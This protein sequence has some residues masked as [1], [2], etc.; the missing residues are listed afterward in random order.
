MAKRALAA[1]RISVKKD[2]STSIERQDDII[3]AWIERERHQH[4][5]TAV[6]RNVSASKTNPFSRPALGPWLN[7]RVADF[8]VLVF[9]RMDRAV[10][11]MGD[12]HKLMD[13]AK[14]YQKQVVFCEGPGSEYEF[15]FTGSGDDSKLELAMLLATVIA[16]AARIESMNV[17]DRVKSSHEYLR[18]NGE[19]GG[20]MIPYGLKPQRKRGA[21]R[22]WELV[23][24][25]ETLPV[26]LDIVD[27]VTSG[28]RL[29]PICNDLN[30]A[31]IPTPR[32]YW[33]D[34]K[35]AERA[36]EYVEGEAP[37]SEPPAKRRLWSTQGL[38]SILTS[39][40]LLGEW[41]FEGSLNVR[42]DGEPIPRCAPILTQT[43]WND[44]QGAL[45]EISIPSK[46]KYSEPNPL[47]GVAMCARC[48]SPFYLKQEKQKGRLYSNL[49]C[50]SRHGGNKSCSQPTI[51]LAYAKEIVEQ[52]TMLAIGSF[53]ATRRQFI[54][55][56]DRSEELARL[57]Q[58]VR[59]LE[60]EWDNELI[61]DR[62]RY[63]E[64]KRKLQSRINEIGDEPVRAAR[65][66]WIGTGKTYEK[67]W[68]ELDPQRRL[69]LLHDLGIKVYLG[70]GD[71]SAA[72]NAVKQQRLLQSVGHRLMAE[73]PPDVTDRMLCDVQDGARIKKG[74]S[75]WLLQSGAAPLN[76]LVSKAGR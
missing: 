36:A 12:L 10:R 30:N 43:Q 17:R 76:E 9:W 20:G 23:H 28:E 19:W 69:K 55:G 33:E 39:R 67:M 48:G 3:R 56:D 61:D 35:R 74:I 27:R 57:Q 71:S 53:E 52:A 68:S 66:E 70:R 45:T 65:Y 4:V 31:Q 18:R 22:G 25:P 7:D 46:Q 37:T 58:R 8:D 2:D 24:N 51:S 14:G 62:A 34:K 26:L 11:S 5:G 13:W 72:E 73:Y 64:R 41:V 44:L 6:D 1:E 38:K 21:A 63:L 40:V 49:S 16:W 54:P 29:L 47:L 32:D 60:D 50:R 59:D 42:D 75:A 15:D